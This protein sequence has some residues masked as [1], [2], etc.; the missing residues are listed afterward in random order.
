MLSF[1]FVKQDEGVYVFYAL[2]LDGLGIKLTELGRSDPSAYLH[3][4]GG[5]GS[6]DSHILQCVRAIRARSEYFD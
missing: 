2:S 4:G 1:F 3:G 5:G 6:A